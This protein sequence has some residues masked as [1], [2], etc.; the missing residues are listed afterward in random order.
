M[1]SVVKETWCSLLGGLKSLATFRH[2]WPQGL[3][4]LRLLKRS[5]QT[6]LRPLQAELSLKRARLCGRF[7]L[8]G[9]EHSL[10]VEPM[11]SAKKGTSY[12][13]RHDA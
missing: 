10:C 12:L 3:S 4:F 8:N 2:A 1:G 11:E 7:H 9:L 5:R 6:G 13:S